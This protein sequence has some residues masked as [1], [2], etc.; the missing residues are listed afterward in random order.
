VERL[1]HTAGG[2]PLDFEDLYFRGDAFQHRLRIARATPA[3]AQSSHT[4][5]GSP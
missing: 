3:P 5:K 2:T 1:T 4:P